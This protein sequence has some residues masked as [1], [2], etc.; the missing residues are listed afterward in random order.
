MT[1]ILMDIVRQVRETVEVALP[2]YL[3]SYVGDEGGSY[4]YTHTWY[5]IRHDEEGLNLVIDT[6]SWYE[7]SLGPGY[8]INRLVTADKKMF[9]LLYDGMLADKLHITTA[10]AYDDAMHK[11]LL[12]MI[13]DHGKKNDQVLADAVREM[14]L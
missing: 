9:N 7:N 12:A 11:A 13:E 2:L 3:H 14:A 8:A 1:T 5:K 6:L 4:R 10:K